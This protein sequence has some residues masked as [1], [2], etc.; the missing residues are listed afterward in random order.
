MVPGTPGHSSIPGGLTHSSQSGGQ[1]PVK[2]LGQDQGPPFA[3]GK[4]LV[5]VGLSSSLLRLFPRG[6]LSVSLPFSSLLRTPAHPNPGGSRLQIPDS[7]TSAETLVQ[8]RSRPMCWALGRGQAPQGPIQP[9]TLPCPCGPYPP[10]TVLQ[11]V[12]HQ[13]LVQLPCLGALCVLL[14]SPRIISEQVALVVL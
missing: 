7:I 5:A 12:L 11:I 1:S 4:L 8:I 2:V 3:A 6:Q 9:S 10:S 13:T 14:G